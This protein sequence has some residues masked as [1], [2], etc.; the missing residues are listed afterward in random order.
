M[1]EPDLIC[2]LNHFIVP[3]H[4]GHWPGGSFGSGDM[5]LCWLVSD[6]TAVP[7]SRHL[8]GIIQNPKNGSLQEEGVEIVQ[9]DRPQ[10]PRS[11]PGLALRVPAIVC[12]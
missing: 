4:F 2:E 3:E 7:K 6:M 1:I 9:K 11:Y 10:L 8:I 5:M 12:T